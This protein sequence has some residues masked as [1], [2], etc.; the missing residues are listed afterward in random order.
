MSEKLFEAYVGDLDPE[1]LERLRYW[2]AAIGLQAV[3]GL[4]PSNYLLEL[5]VR[6]IKGE[7]SFTEVNELI[8]AHYERRRG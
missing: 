2:R 8:E 6:N 1:G 4:Q 3:D 7:I 5:A